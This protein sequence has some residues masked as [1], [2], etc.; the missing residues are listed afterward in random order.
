MSK[1]VI[2]RRLLHNINNI[3]ISGVV[4]GAKGAKFL[5][6]G[7]FFFLALN[8]LSRNSET[9]LKI[10]FNTIYNNNSPLRIDNSYNF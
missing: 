3:P 7:R 10:I 2:Y 9:V 4:R 8:Y 1:H 5:Q 6:I